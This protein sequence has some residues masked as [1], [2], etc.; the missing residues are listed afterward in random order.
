MKQ[1]FNRE[2]LEVMLW[3]RGLKSGERWNI[4]VVPTEIPACSRAALLVPQVQILVMSHTAQ[5][6]L[7]ANNRNDGTNVRKSNYTFFCFQE[8]DHQTVL[9]L[10]LHSIKYEI[11]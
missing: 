5:I 1:L 4:R 6:G 2:F 7:P 11:L 3:V 8:T 9:L 10:I